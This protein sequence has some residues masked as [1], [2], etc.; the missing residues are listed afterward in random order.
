MNKISQFYGMTIYMDPNNM[1]TKKPA[2]LFNHPNIIVKYQDYIGYYS[3]PMI[4]LIWGDFPPSGDED[5]KEW[6][7][8]NQ[9]KLEYMYANHYLEDI[10]PLE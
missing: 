7:K 4:E 1:D 8:I 2:M 6:I 5:I 9:D 10:K 3:I